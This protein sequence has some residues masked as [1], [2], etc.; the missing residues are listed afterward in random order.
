MEIYT[1]FLNGTALSFCLLFT[2]LKDFE[3]K[4]FIDCNDVYV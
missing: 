2:L 4:N 3:R 1:C